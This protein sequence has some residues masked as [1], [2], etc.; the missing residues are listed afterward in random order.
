MKIGDEVLYQ[1]SLRGVVLSTSGCDRKEKVDLLFEDGRW[2]LGLRV[3]SL[4]LNPHWLLTG[5]SV[6]SEDRYLWNMRKEN[7]DTYIYSVSFR[8]KYLSKGVSKL[9]QNTIYVEANGADS[10]RDF[11]LDVLQSAG[12]KGDSRD[13]D[14][15]ELA[16]CQLSNPNFG[17]KTAL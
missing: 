8:V 15:I 11:V 17:V 12:F 10:A 9:D 6:S 13:I 4:I 3:D 16:T 14:S 1:A 2:F 7:R 5:C